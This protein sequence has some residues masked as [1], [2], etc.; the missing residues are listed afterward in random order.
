MRLGF[1]ENPFA[2]A[3]QIFVLAALQGP[4][5]GDET[6]EAEEQRGRDEIDE[7]THVLLPFG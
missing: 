4:E 7:Y 6:G 2:R 5:E 3:V 1:D